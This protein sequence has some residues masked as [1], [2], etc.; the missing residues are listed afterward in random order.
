MYFLSFLRYYDSTKWNLHQ[1]DSSLCDTRTIFS[2]FFVNFLVGI[3]Q[4]QSVTPLLGDCKSYFGSNKFLETTNYLSLN[5]L[6]IFSSKCAEGST[7]M[8]G[9]EHEKSASAPKIPTTIWQCLPTKHCGKKDA[10]SNDKITLFLVLDFMSLLFTFH[11]LWKQT[12]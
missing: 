3:S 2:N 7:E 10:E 12:L 11:K 6:S 4:T 1:G 9:K 5:F 8:P